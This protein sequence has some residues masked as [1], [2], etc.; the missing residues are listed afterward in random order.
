MSWK[1]YNHICFA[2]L[3]FGGKSFNP[4]CRVS[5]ILTVSLR[6]NTRIGCFIYGLSSHWIHTQFCSYLGR[7]YRLDVRAVGPT[8]PIAMHYGKE[9]RKG[10]L[11]QNNEIQNHLLKRY[12]QNCLI[13]PRNRAMKSSA[14]QY[15]APP[16]RWSSP[17]SWSLGW[18]QLF[19]KDK[20]FTHFQISVLQLS[21]SPLLPHICSPPKTDQLNCA[22]CS[23]GGARNPAAGVVTNL[24]E[25]S[26][27]L[28]C[29]AVKHCSIFNQANTCG[30][31]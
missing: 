21:N 19:W 30:W 11:H 27:V 8:A 28:W 12:K 24:G 15:T 9:E 26:E 7:K 25:V 31:N 22:V 2:I 29:H 13:A 5:K 23:D 6:R 4:V 14:G 20:Y 3:I 10:I 17:F 18:L 16:A 1:Y